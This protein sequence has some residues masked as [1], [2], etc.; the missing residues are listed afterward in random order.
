MLKRAF[1]YFFTEVYNILSFA[2]QFFKEMF[3]PPF[4]FMETLMQSFSI[5]FKSLPL[6]GV[7]ALVMGIVLV[8][9][10]RPALVEFGAGS[11]VPS[12]AAVSIIREIG[13]M[14]TG[15][16]CAGNIGSSISAELGT[17]KVT[18]QIDAMEVSGTNPFKYLVVTRIIASTLI[19]PLL[20]VYSDTVSLFGSYLGANIKDDISLIAFFD[21]V[22]E[23][24]G[25]KDIFPSLIK[26][27]FFG[28]AIGLVGCY[29]G[30][31]TQKG[32]EG[33][34]KSANAA[35]IISMLFVILIDM[36]AAQ[37]SSIFHL[38]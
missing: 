18:E 8:L 36:V 16:V 3:S 23:K 7:T 37:V 22:F 1:I 34:G 17:M 28:F 11:Y 24:L 13:P 9:Q 6:V 27:F 5:G 19:I 14:I 31:T 10:S 35:V 33:V 12:M 30:Y 29:K 21:G 15:M 2:I 25:F 32:S 26:T 4:E 20:V 38:L